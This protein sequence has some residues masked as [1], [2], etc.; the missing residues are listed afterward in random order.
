M[1]Y[2]G[3]W[4]LKEEPFSTSPDPKFFY[5]TNKHKSALNKLEIGIRLKRGLSLILGPIGSGKT[6]LSRSLLKRF[7]NNEVDNNIQFYFIFDPSFRSEFDFLH[8]LTR[9]FGLKKVGRS[10]NHCKEAIENFLFEQNETKKKNVILVI[11]EAQK[12]TTDILESLRVLLN[13]ESNEAKFLQLI[14]LGQPELYKKIFKMPNLVDRIYLQFALEPLTAEETSNLLHF[15]LHQAGMDNPEKYLS[16][17]IVD[18]IWEESH[19][20]P[21]RINHLCHLAL[22][23]CIAEEQSCFTVKA[24]Q[25]IINEEKYFH[26]RFNIS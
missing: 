21:R 23:K 14:L 13:Y 25:E 2:F 26:E 9:I 5:L 11:D 18:Y 22:A 20:L 10:A 15:R 17:N 6:T 7:N 12:L 16:S 8:T 1:S 4:G 19:G 3:I 24:I